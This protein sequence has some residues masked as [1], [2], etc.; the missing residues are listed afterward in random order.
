MS[1]IQLKSITK[2]YDSFEA[3][4]Q[5]N[6]EI[7]K[8]IFVTLL[9]PSG[10][11]KTTTL[12]MIAGLIRPT[13]G[14][15]SIDGRILSSNDTFVPPEERKLGMVFQ[16]YA[17]W[18][19]MNVFDNVAYP[20]KKQK[21]SKDEIRQVTTE[22]LKM[23]RLEGLENR[24]P[25]ELSGG[26]QQRVALARALTMRPLGLLLD[27]PLSNLDSK[28]RE[29]MR[30]E[31]K[32]IQRK[33]QITIVYVTHD[34]SEAMTMSDKI[35]VMEKGKI[36]QSGSPEDIYFTPNSQRV[37]AFI[38][39]NNFINATVEI[40]D[41]QKNL[42]T[43]CG[44]D[45]KFVGLENFKPQQGVVISVKSEDINMTPDVNGTFIV[46]NR[47]FVG[48]HT[49]YELI[50]GDLIINSSQTAI[51]RINVGDRVSVSLNKYTIFSQQ[52]S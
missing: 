11:G 49:D 20:L 52:K 9:G 26:Q 39:C 8:G 46:K 38:G 21:K 33:M 25:F 6:L 29:E 1:Y 45:Q 32:D 13:E 37:A 4:S 16:S 23:V 35:V 3:V 12:R 30:F 28:L 14:E 19:H 31:I 2:R 7:E 22:V 50:C 51:Q 47:A 41:N 15:I 42:C 36:L 43:D 24:M 17:V 34:L 44:I 27:E 48:D 5:M 10:C 40:K 18:P